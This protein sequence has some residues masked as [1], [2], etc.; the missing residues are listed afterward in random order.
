[1]NSL[2][3]APT[4]IE[5]LKGSDK[6]EKESAKRHSLASKRTTTPNQNQRTSSKEINSS[7]TTVALKKSYSFMKSTACQKSVEN[8]ATSKRSLSKSSVMLKQESTKQVTPA[9]KRPKTPTQTGNQH[10]QF[11]QISCVNTAK[12][13]L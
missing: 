2:K 12:K 13:E 8:A 5:N 7:K 4:T 10:I 6:I 11:N 3:K 9:L 1:M